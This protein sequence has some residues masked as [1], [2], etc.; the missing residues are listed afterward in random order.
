MVGLQNIIDKTLAEQSGHSFRR[1]VESYAT[2]RNG[3]N[4]VMLQRMRDCSAAWHTCLEMRTLQIFS[5]S[6][7]IEDELPKFTGQELIDAGRQMFGPHFKFK[8]DQQQATSDVANCFSTTVAINSGKT[9]CCLIAMLA[10][11]NF[12]RRQSD[13]HRKIYLVT[14]LVVPYVSTLNSTIRQ[15]TDLGF[16]VRTFHGADGS[17][18]DY[19]VLLMSLEDGHLRYLNQV[20]RHFESVAHQGR[21]YLR[22]VVVDDAHIL[23]MKDFVVDGNRNV[24]VVFLTSFLPQVSDN[25]MRTLFSLN[26]LGR[27]SS[28]D[29]ILPHKEFTLVKKPNAAS[30]NQTISYRVRS[31]GSALVLV[32]SYENVLY[33]EHRLAEEGVPCIGVCGIPQRRTAALE[34]MASENIKVVVTTA[35]AMVGLHQFEA[36]TVLFAYSI[37]NPIEL[38][39]ASQFS[40]GKVEMVLYNTCSSAFQR[41]LSNNC[42]NLILMRHMRMTEETCYDAGKEQCHICA[43][44]RRRG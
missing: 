21:T 24:P 6:I 10:E 40:S 25:S 12:S 33:L 16:K 1:F 39:V 37:R 8:R 31:L 28:Q 35:E 23:Q 36:T 20:V 3:Y 15:L 18:T 5:P 9:T 27:V 11:L 42:V 19:D 14:I 26:R 41:E 17:V 7:W 29:P 30:I 2:D 44:K 4:N 22:R 34:K 43:N 32:Q 38:L 13:R